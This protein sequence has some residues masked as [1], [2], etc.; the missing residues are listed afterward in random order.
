[1]NMKDDR[2][3]KAL[4]WLEEI[5]GFCSSEEKYI[6]ATTLQAEIER[7]KAKLKDEEAK[8]KIAASVIERQDKEIER[9]EIE[10]DAMRGAANSYKFH[11]NESKSEAIKE[12]VERLKKVWWNNGYESPDVDFDDFIDNLVKEMVGE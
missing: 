2:I 6:Y 7:L 9:L 4:E 11:Y 10:L 1:M 3:K 5:K 8:N 12:F